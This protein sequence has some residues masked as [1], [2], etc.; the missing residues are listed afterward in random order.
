M[1]K[2]TNKTIKYTIIISD[3]AHSI[4]TEFIISTNTTFKKMHS[5]SYY[6]EHVHDILTGL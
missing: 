1:Q 6:N 2:K 4:I 5:D 3:A